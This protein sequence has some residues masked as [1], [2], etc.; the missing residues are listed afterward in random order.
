[1]KDMPK[2][3]AFLKKFI[4]GT[5]REFYWRIYGRAI[6]NPQMPDAPGSFLFICKGNICRSPFAEHLAKKIAQKKKVSVEAVIDTF[7]ALEYR[8]RNDLYWHNG[9]TWDEQIAGIGEILQHLCNV[10][11]EAKL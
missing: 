10:I 2:R 8:R 5:T 1:M 11:E 6:Q 3:S 4:K 9:D 7:K